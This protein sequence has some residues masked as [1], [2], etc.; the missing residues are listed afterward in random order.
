MDRVKREGDKFLVDKERIFDLAGRFIFFVDF[1]LGE[2][3]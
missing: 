2:I 3:Y 1:I